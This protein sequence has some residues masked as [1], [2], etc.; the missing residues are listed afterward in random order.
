MR[1]EE[2]QR[3]I[4]VNTYYK[5]NGKII[6][7]VQRNGWSTFASNSDGGNAEAIHK[8]AA[9]RGL[10]REGLSDLLANHYTAS[11]CGKYGARLEVLH[12]ADA[13]SAPTSGEVFDE[14]FARQSGGGMN[15]L[16]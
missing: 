6:A 4:K 15:K 10:S 1:Q 12:Y 5:V 7:V 9:R 14:M 13:A 8:L 3:A 16:V 11:L 2:K